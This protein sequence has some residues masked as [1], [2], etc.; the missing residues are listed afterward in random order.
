MSEVSLYVNGNRF[1]DWIEVSIKHSI[2]SLSSQF[3]LTVAPPKVDLSKLGLRPNDECRLEVDGRPVITGYVDSVSLS[4]S[5]S[6]VGYSISGRSKTSDLVDCS[7]RD[8]THSFENISPIA[9]IKKIASKFNIRVASNLSLKNL[10]QFSISPGESAWESIS[11]IVSKYGLI[12]YPNGTGGL[13]ITD[14]TEGIFNAHIIDSENA[15]SFNISFDGSQRFSEYYVV[16]QAPTDDFFNGENANQSEGM[17]TDSYTKRYRPLII[18]AE[19]GSD[20]SSAKDRAQFEASRRAAES[21]R[22]SVSMPSWINE[23]N[24]LWA[25]NKEVQITC[26]YFGLKNYALISSVELKKTAGSESV[27]IELE[28]VNAYLKQ[29]KIQREDFWEVFDA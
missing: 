17:A 10:K 12:V 13:V 6:S 18:E 2:N 23:E 19:T 15:P 9:L 29:P 20:S 3:D 22:I 27:S 28:N 11:K 1:S 4:V 5:G 26:N 14:E 24:E 7:Y 25:I 16:S 8:K 21:T